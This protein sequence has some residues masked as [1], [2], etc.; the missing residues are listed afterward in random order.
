MTR[1]FSKVPPLVAFALLVAGH[2]MAQKDTKVFSEMPLV[3]K[4][5]VFIGITGG[6]SIPTG[7]FAKTDYEDNTSGFASTGFNV[8]IAGTRMLSRHWGVTG[9]AAFTR[10]NTAGLKSIAAGFVES[11]AV[12]DATVR[13]QGNNQTFSYMVGGYYSYPFCSKFAVDIRAMT[14]LVR[15][16]LAGYEVQ[17]EDNASSAFQQKTANANTIGFQAGAAA[18]YNFSK[19]FGL[20]FNLDYYYSKPDFEIE[21]VNRTN[22]AGRLLTS[23]NEPIAGVNANFSLVYTMNRK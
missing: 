1:F 4:P 14:G 9:M 8:G 6:V 13:A 3:V 18:R 17:L 2:A 22:Y 16:Q 19:H 10:Y 12:G 7:N 11:F 15:A 5:P 23:Y 21:N 20:M